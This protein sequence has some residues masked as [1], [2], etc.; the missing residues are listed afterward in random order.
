MYLFNPLALPVHHLRWID[1]FARF[2]QQCSKAVS[3][4]SKEFPATYFGIIINVRWLPTGTNLRF[5]FF[6]HRTF[7][8]MVRRGLEESFNRTGWAVLAQIENNSTHT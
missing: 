6:I 4:L 5:L 8:Q 3:A 2:C 1:K 7:Y